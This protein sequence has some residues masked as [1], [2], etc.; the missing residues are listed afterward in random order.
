MKNGKIQNL[1]YN[2]LY[3]NGNNY[4]KNVKL[5]YI[6]GKHHIYNGNNYVLNGNI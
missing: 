3:I 4:V 1:N 2:H 5:I 6:N